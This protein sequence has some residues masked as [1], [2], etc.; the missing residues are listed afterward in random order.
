MPQTA[1]AAVHDT[2]RVTILGCGSSGG[3]PRV[4]TDWGAC[5]P[6]EPRNTRTRCSALFE[7]VGTRGVTRVLIDTSP[8]LRAQLLRAGVGILDGVLY[9]HEHA[10]H[11]HGIDDLRVVVQNR[12]TRLPI[13]A[14]RETCKVLTA[15]FGYT[16]VQAPGT[17]YPPILE[18]NRID[19]API[20]IAGA[21]GAL[22]FQPFKVHHGPCATLGFRCADVAYVPDVS[23]FPPASLPCL[24]NLRLWIVDA[25]RRAPHKTHLH[26]A[27]TLAW[28][29]DMA[30]AEAVL[31]NL[32]TDLDYAT[33]QAETPGHVHPAHDGLCRVLP[34]VDA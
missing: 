28:I 5:D 31:T 2:L 15:R 17:L 18:M 3:V 20:T 34:L 30:P 14:T 23:D 32:H 19:T 9:T 11:V 26:L 33:L 6:N 16:F 29:A 22:S 12:R 10:D 4:G 7:R 8:D 25:L 24:E 27:R 13:W 21:G 1:P